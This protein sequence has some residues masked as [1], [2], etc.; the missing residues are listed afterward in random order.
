MDKELSYSKNT[1]SS[2]NGHISSHTEV[3][4]GVLQG[5]VITPYFFAIH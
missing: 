1:A 3:T 5:S 2:R 4:T